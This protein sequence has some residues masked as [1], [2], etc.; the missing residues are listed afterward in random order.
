MLLLQAFVEYLSV[1]VSLCVMYSGV[2][3]C[4]E[5]YTCPLEYMT[6]KVL[7]GLLCLLFTVVLCVGDCVRQRRGS[8]VLRLLPSPVVG[9]A[10]LTPAAVN[11][12]GYTG[13][14]A[15]GSTGTAARQ[16]GFVYRTSGP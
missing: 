1:S 7:V 3:V 2:T 12:A 9:S 15:H 8:G 4:P 13:P 6:R 16:R 10:T 5:E 14:A 11:V